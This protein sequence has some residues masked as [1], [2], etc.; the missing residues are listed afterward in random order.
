MKCPYCSSSLIRPSR[1]R[2]SDS[3]RLVIGRFPMRCREC[4]SRFFTWLPQML[5]FKRLEQSKSQRDA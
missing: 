2:M 5:S 4:R 3:A 1:L